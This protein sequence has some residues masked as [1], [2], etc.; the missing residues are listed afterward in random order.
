MMSPQKKDKS[1]LPGSKKPKKQ[2]KVKKAADKEMIRLVQELKQAEEKY[3]NIIENIGVGVAMID[4]AMRILTLNRQMREWFPDV[5]PS[6]KPL[7][8][9]SFNDPPAREICSYCPTISTLRDG[10]VHEAV[11]HTP[12]GEGVKNFRIIA[13]PVTDSDGRV[14]AAI[15]MVE[16]ITE[17]RRAEEALRA[18]EQRH[19]SYIELTGQFSWTTNADGELMEDLP[20]WRNF[21]G[22]SEE[23]IKGAG[24]A[25]AL[26][27][28]DV[29][30]ALEAW[31]KAV[32]AKSAY[33]VEYRVR[34][35]DGVYRHW[36]ARG[37]PLFK[38]DGSIREWIGTSIDITDM[39]LAGEELKKSESMYRTIFETTPAATMIVEEDT[40][41]SMVNREFAT[42]TGYNANEVEGKKSWTEYILKEDLERVIGYHRL[43]RIN[44][45]ASPR[46]YEFRYTDKK[47]RLRDVYAT[48]ALMPGT[49]KTVLSLLDITDRKRAEESLRT[50]SDELKSKSR[51]L[52]EMNAALRVLLKQRED[53]K[54][55]LEERVLASVKEL[56]MPHLEELKKCLSDQREL[57]H[58]Q[59]LESNLKGIISPFAQKLSLQFLHLTQKEI[60]I[61]NLIK[62]GKTTKEIARFMNLSK[63]AIDTHRAHL[64]NKLGLT[65]KKANLRTYLSSI[66]K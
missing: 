10:Q 24:W 2:A 26:H 1:I 55:E 22:Q 15:E 17:R 65:N 11:T 32:A 16:D 62:E 46:N 47:G 64:R 34:R 48:V 19:R 43:R 28:D 41:I 23:E 51:T 5:N 39:K 42:Q 9:E 50:N 44:P 35:R 8:Y 33:E 56:V 13:T 54:T 60:R 58:V 30:R 45:E 63:F 66:Q 20:A 40:T 14:V 61:A 25:K 38:E 31:N 27:P 21:T 7:C 6:L 53:D 37:V 29:E 59:I 57:T 4:P 36:L 18:S 52:E 49:Q 12:S 3:R